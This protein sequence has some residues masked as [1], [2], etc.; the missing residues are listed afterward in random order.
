MRSVVVS[1][2]LTIRVSLRDRA[3]LQLEILALR[4]Q[5]H[6]LNRSRP[7]RLRLTQA[8]RMLW[9]WLLRVWEDWR[10]ALVIVKPE[11]VLAWHRRGFRVFWTW[12]SRCHVGR[13]SVPRDVRQLIR[14]MADANPLWARHAFTANS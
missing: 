8:D 6:V 13:P 11:T 10:A 9:V 12:K 7:Q 2:L 4:H 5:L 3:A 14:T 1:L